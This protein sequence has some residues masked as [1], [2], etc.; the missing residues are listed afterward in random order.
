MDRKILE[1]MMAKAKRKTD[2]RD[3]LRV[4]DNYIK[5][6]EKFTSKNGGFDTLVLTYNGDKYS[7][8]E[9]DNIEQIETL[10]EVISEF[11][12]KNYIT[13]VNTELGNYYP[14][15]HN[16]NY[17]YVGADWGQGAS[18]YCTR[19]EDAEES[20]LNYIDVIHN[21]KLPETMRKEA[22]LEELSR[23]I[24]SLFYDDNLPVDVIE[25]QTNEAFQK[26]RNKEQ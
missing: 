10:Y 24:D 11:A 26:I 5:W 18:F 13:P 19:L 25:N 12:E 17:F 9:R 23:I 1:K 21:I 15:K 2:F 8:E 4:N 7:E 20:A 14:I 3:S 22:R 16:D 6:L